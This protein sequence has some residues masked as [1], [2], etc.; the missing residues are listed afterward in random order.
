M[1]GGICGIVIAVIAC[2][3]SRR[4]NIVAVIVG[5]TVAGTVII[6]GIAII[7][8]G[9]GVIAVAVTIAGVAIGGVVRIA[10]IIGRGTIGDITIGVVGVYGS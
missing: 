5:G 9:R 10:V 2:S 7:R 3:I 1:I 4:T 8:I 6:A